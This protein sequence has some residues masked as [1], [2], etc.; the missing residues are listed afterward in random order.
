MRWAGLLALFVV[1]CADPETTVRSLA[2]SIVLEPPAFDDRAVVAEEPH[3]IRANRGITGGRIE[4]GPAGRSIDGLPAAV[5]V[6][7]RLADVA[8]L[9]RRGTGDGTDGHSGRTDA[10]VRD[11][12]A[13]VGSHT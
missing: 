7:C 12:D 2:V 1:A 3:M 11:E 4:V 9:R 10:P 8:T 6:L 13:G 5:R